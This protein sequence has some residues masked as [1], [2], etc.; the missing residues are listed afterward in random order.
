MTTLADR[1]VVVTGA[2]SGIG[3][4]IVAA[5]K[6]AGAAL[7][8]L[9]LT[10]GTGIRTFDVTDEAAWSQLADELHAGNTPVHG[11]VNCAGTTWRARLGDVTPADFARVQAV[12]VLGPL[13][14]IQALAPLMA[15][16]AS[17][18]NIGSLAA[19]QGH[20]PVAYTASKWS[21]RGVTHAAC[22]ELG[23]RGIRVNIVHPGFIETAMTASAPPAFRTAALA[24]T[25]L[26]RPGTARE[27]A[28]VAV[29]LL[30]D[31]ASFVSGA[32][33]SVDGGA[34]SHG[35]AKTVSDALRPSYSPPPLGRI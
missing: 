11:L 9:D 10:P 23:P 2:A 18:V 16:G 12:N 8:P 20:Y 22:L 32:E 33:I 6:A 30:A 27:V 15:A 26:G 7:I 17:I 5:A 34:G 29:F 14:G 21:L 24:E 3:A 19:L 25:P 4:A 31:A 1:T 35:G 13:L 28:S